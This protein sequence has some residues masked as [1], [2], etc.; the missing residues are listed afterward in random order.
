MTLKLYAIK[1][2]L[3]G[4]LFPNHYPNDETAR[5]AMKL[6]REEDQMIKSNPDDYEM[7]YIG[8][9]ETESAIMENNDIYPVE[10]NF[11][12]RSDKE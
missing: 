9:Y 4:Y 8:T 5:R 3:N 11:E 1:D 10:R 2:K 7:W 12:E 6:V